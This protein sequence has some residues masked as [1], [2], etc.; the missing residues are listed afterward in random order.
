MAPR[1]DRPVR[2]RH[3]DNPRRRHPHRVLKAPSRTSTPVRRVLECS[4]D[5]AQDRLAGR[6]RNLSFLNTEREHTTPLTG[7]RG[8]RQIGR[9][10]PPTS[11]CR[12]FVARPHPH[13]S[14][15]SLAGHVAASGPH[16]G[17]Q[18]SP[19][20]PNGVRV[21]PGAAHRHRSAPR[22]SFT[23]WAAETAVAANGRPARS[24][25][26]PGAVVRRGGAVGRG[27]GRVGR[28]SISARIRIGRACRGALPR[29]SPVHDRVG[30]VRLVQVAPIRRLAVAALPGRRPLDLRRSSA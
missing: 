17:D 25:P 1:V 5:T 23:S 26:T 18:L 15:Q 11:F 10:D 3:A 20:A 13:I 19:R 24:A 16:G 12:R 22:T 9:S 8:P 4:S 28:P 29:R 7:G 21:D 27:V 30:A 6:V 14:G 2:K